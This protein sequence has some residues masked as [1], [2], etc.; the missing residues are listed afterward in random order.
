MH[1]NV[2]LLLLIAILAFT[3]PPAQAQPATHIVQPGETLYRIA[4]NYG[5]RSPGLA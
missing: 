3:V 5:V 4:A 1:Q 2:C